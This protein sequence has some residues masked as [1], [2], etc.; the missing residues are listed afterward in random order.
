MKKLIYFT[1]SAIPTTAEKADIMSV[2]GKV[3]QSIQLVV[4]AGDEATNYGSNESP[5]DYVSGTVPEAFSS[6]PVFTDEDAYQLKS[7]ETIISSGQKL[8]TVDGGSVTFSIVDTIASAT[9][10][11]KSTDALISSGQ[12]VTA[13]DGGTITL[14]VADGV[15]SATY[16]AKAA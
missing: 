4:M 6:V 5:A 3:I 15:L 12:T 14:T 1:K 9:F 16:A 2:R 7:T 8:D 11:A 10:T 13:D